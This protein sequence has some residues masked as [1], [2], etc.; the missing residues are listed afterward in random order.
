[1]AETLP[2][3]DIKVPFK[4]VSDTEKKE[5]IKSK[6]AS[7]TKK[8]TKLWLNCFDDYLIEKDLPKID[9]IDTSDLPQILEQFYLK[10]RKKNKSSDKN[11]ADS[12]SDSDGGMSYRNTTM[13][14]I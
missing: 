4:T 3:I 2:K 7:K 13:K 1:M 14:S 10:V 12:E 6:D 8:A 9:E 11:G 5:I